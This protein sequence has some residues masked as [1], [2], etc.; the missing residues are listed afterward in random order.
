MHQWSAEWIYW[1]YIWTKR[2]VSFGFCFKLSIYFFFVILMNVTWHRNSPRRWPWAALE[3]L[4]VYR[5]LGALR[6]KNDTTDG[7]VVLEQKWLT[8]APENRPKPKVN[9]VYQ[10]SIFRLVLA[11]V[12]APFFVVGWT[13]D[14]VWPWDMLKFSMRLLIPFPKK[15]FLFQF[16]LRFFGKV[17]RCET[18]RPTTMSEAMTYCPW[19]DEGVAADRGHTGG[20]VVLSFTSSIMSIFAPFLGT[21][22]KYMG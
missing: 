13:T 21:T 4:R 14:H 11:S 7:M 15:P 6:K 20:H 12:L 16:L 1:W 3:P 19:Q 17:S 8:Y 18:W 22:W 2:N 9:V 10:P 5:E